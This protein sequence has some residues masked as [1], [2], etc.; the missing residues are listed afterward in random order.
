MKAIS[1]SLIAT[2][3]L[4]LLQ[5]F[6]CFGYWSRFQYQDD[7]ELPSFTLV[8]GALSLTSHFNQASIPLILLGQHPPRHILFQTL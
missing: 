4:G 1:S 5:T 2:N 6:I 7:M 8:T 3:Q